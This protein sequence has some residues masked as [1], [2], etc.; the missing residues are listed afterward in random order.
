MAVGCA[1]SNLAVGTNTQK[2]LEILGV[3]FRLI[4]SNAIYKPFVY[5][6]FYLILHFITP[7]FTVYP[8]LR[9]STRIN[10]K[11]LVLLLVHGTIPQKSTNKTAE[12]AA[13]F[14]VWKNQKAPTFLKGCLPCRLKP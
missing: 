2:R 13:P 4:P 11:M 9:K 6:R 14:G 10:I 8:R 7:R 3:F 5:K 12:T 1:S